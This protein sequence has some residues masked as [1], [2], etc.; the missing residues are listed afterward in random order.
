MNN[1]IKTYMLTKSYGKSRGI[2]DLNL[3]VD[4]GDFFGFIG[5]NGAGKSTTIR[6]LLGLIHPT[7]GRAEILGKPL[8]R[9]TE[10][11]TEVGYIPSECIFYPGMRVGELIKYSAGIRKKDCSAEAK[12]LCDRLCLDIK[13]KIDQLSMGNRKKTAIVC[14]MQHRPSL[15]IL[16][17]PTSGLDPLMQNE[18]FNLLKERNKEGA[19]IFFSSH[20]LSEIQ[21]NCNKAAIIKDGKLAALDSVD[22]LSQSNTK[23]VTLHGINF[24]PEALPVES[25]SISE[26][27]VSFLYHGDIK[28]LISK[29][30]LL[31]ISDMTINEPE[32]EEIF[33]HYYSGEEK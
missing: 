28:L 7:S 33:M 20:I 2:T 17:E 26:N 1:A 16:D 8:K 9:I 29:I 18:F 4:E 23:R 27:S 32:L 13:M 24:L 22:N 10:I 31:P 25:L 15:Y 19:T 6:T 14:A 5:P 3:I 21:H 30:N 12:I 11:L